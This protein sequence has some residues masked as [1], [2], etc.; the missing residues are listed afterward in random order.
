MMW[1]FGGIIVPPIAGGAMDLIG[2]PGLP[3]TLGIMCLL[4][5][6]LSIARWRRPRAAAASWASTRR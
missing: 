4:L 2:A 1:G 3:L 5:V 6:V